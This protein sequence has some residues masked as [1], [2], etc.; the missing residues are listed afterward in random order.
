MGNKLILIVIA[1]FAAAL[2]VMA[3]DYSNDL[4]KEAFVE[5]ERPEDSYLAKFWAREQVE[6]LRNE[7]LKMISKLKLIVRNNPEE[8]G[9][10]NEYAKIQ[11]GYKGAEELFYKRNVIY[12]RVEFENNLKN[13]NNL[14]RK[15][16][17]K[18]KKDA[19][20]MIDLCA[21]SLFILF[22]K[23]NQKAL[24]KYF[25]Q[26]KRLQYL[27]WLGIAYAQL[28]HAAI[29]EKKYITEPVIFHYRQAKK[30]A[31]SILEN[32]PARVKQKRLNRYIEK[33]HRKRFAYLIRKMKSI[34]I[35]KNKADCNNTY[36]T[37]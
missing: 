10:K 26:K 33:K 25:P 7:N 37:K 17:K 24:R 27:T 2:P 21:E 20:A 8:R 28:D 5:A 36:Y 16:S 12:S 18:Y 34:N 3:Q 4:Y 23:S 14:F 30:Y 1:A 31:I 13:I 11:V 29:N 15:I 35:A 22:Q 19:N 9:W 32:L 6:I